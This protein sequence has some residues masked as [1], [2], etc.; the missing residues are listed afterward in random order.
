MWM[1]YFELSTLQLLNY[2]DSFLQG[3]YWLCSE[4]CMH[5]YIDEEGITLQR[6]ARILVPHGNNNN[7]SLM[8]CVTV[9]REGGRE[10]EREREGEEQGK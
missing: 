4:S 7:A 5:K 1:K 10:R 2:S 9:L 6:T 3:S 8:S